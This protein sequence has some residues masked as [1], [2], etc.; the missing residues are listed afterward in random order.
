MVF[1]KEEKTCTQTY[2]YLS[3]AGN[4]LADSAHLAPR[5][6]ARREERATTL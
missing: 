5:N 3:Q 2:L 4:A 1:S 6:N